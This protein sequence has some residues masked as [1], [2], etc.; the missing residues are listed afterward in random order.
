MDF[1]NG[2]TNGNVD[3]PVIAMDYTVS[4]YHDK[5]NAVTVKQAEAAAGKS[6]NVNQAYSLFYDGNA[7]GETT[8]TGKNGF[9]NSGTTPINPEFCAKDNVGNRLGCWSQDPDP[10]LYYKGKGMEGLIKA[11]APSNSVIT[12]TATGSKL[13]EVA[14]LQDC[15]EKS[16]GDASLFFE[17]FFANFFEV[18]WVWNWFNV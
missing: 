13:P 3:F 11:V 2:A 6:A 14:T 1:R 10:D 15:F 5:R 16:D 9:L 4:V 18:I 7:P 17:L 8:T 12:P